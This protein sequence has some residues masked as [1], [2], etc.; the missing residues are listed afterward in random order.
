MM[1]YGYITT[2]YY[3]RLGKTGKIAKNKR[4]VHRSIRPLTLALAMQLAYLFPRKIGS[5]HY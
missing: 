1:I 5:Y 2:T 3:S 4:A